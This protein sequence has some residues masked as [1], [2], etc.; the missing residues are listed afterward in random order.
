MEGSVI[1]MDRI[2]NEIIN[3]N[4]MKRFI[5]N[6]TKDTQYYRTMNIKDFTEPITILL[7][8]NGSGKSMTLRDLEIS[9]KEKDTRVIHYSTSNDDIVKKCSGPFNFDPM[10]LVYAFHSEGERMIGSFQKWS[11]SFMLKEILTHQEPLYVL[12]DE[13]DSGLSIDRLMQS[14]LQLK[15]IISAERKKGRELYFIFTV[16]SYEMLEVLQSDM[17]EIVWVPT[18]EKI[19]LDSYNEFKS[20]Y[21]YYYDNYYED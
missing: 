3:I 21:K 13:A 1:Q 5:A 11:N 19:E 10:G 6:K 12:I 7:G 2:V 18:K 16:N 14:L 9:L 8:P 4:K 20:L 17:T 15:H